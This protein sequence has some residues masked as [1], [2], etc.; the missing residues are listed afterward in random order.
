LAT[1]SKPSVYNGLGVLKARA[2]TAVAA[3][4]TFGVDMVVVVAD[5]V[6]KDGIECGGGRR[7]MSCVI[8]WWV[9]AM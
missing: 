8:V 5:V 3:A 4:A 9:V 6:M 1:T 7:E 2:R